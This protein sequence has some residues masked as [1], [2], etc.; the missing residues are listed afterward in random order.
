M[1][2]RHS[3]QFSHVDLASSSPAAHTTT[4]FNISTP[5]TPITSSSSFYAAASSYQRP[6]RRLLI[7]AAALFF[8]LIALLHQNGD[9]VVKPISNQLPDLKKWSTSTGNGLSRVFGGD[10]HAHA[11]TDKRITL[12]AL[13]WVKLY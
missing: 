3:R 9:Q 6:S 1:S 12:I 10:A 4:T 7:L 11:S 8:T 5:S 2:R 13:W